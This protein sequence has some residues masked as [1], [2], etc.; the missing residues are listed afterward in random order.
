[1]SLPHLFDGC[2]E[3]RLLVDTVCF[4]A[5][6]VSVN[7]I[8][9]QENAYAA[10]RFIGF[11]IA[12]FNQTVSFLSTTMNSSVSIPVRVVFSHK[13]GH[14]VQLVVFYQRGEDEYL[15]HGQ[16]MPVTDNQTAAA[17]HE[18]FGLHAGAYDR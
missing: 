17:L 4:Y 18:S 1:M 10:F 5:L 14:V 13:N 11:S 8:I 6:Q 3:N 2:L 16:M 9:F 7:I 12:T 15:W